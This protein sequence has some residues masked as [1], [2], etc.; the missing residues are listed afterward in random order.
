MV[1]AEAGGVAEAQT[2]M[3]VERSMA[4]LNWVLGGLL[5]VVVGVIVLMTFQT[6]IHEFDVNSGRTRRVH[7]VPGI[8]TRAERPEDT[9]LSRVVDPSG[10]PEW[11]PYHRDAPWSGTIVDYRLGGV[12]GVIRQFEW[13]DEDPGFTDD[14]R[15]LIV[16][17]IRDSIRETSNE[18]QAVLYFR[19]CAGLL[20]RQLGS[21][22]NQAQ[23]P[24]LL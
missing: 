22:N 24:R 6:T 3:R 10:S 21:L 13:L 18:W 15:Q 8:S 16:R 11:H 2:G 12:T 7:Y 14:A 5:T 4:M 23:P 19:D 17:R 1:E 9:W 20:D